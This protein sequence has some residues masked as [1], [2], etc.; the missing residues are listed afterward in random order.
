MKLPTSRPPT[1]AGRILAELWEHP[2][3]AS[4]AQLALILDI[5]HQ[6]VNAACRAMAARHL[7]VRE[8]RDGTII[9][10]ALVRELPVR[11]V[12]PPQDAP[13][14]WEG[15]VQATVATFLAGEG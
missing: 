7:I 4:D 12:T 11:A 5:R 6:L 13:W 15:N 3:G 1:H 8:S 2:D 14:F 10:R 9:N